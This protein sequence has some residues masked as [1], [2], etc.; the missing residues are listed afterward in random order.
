[1]TIEMFLILLT[2]FSV[3]TSLCTEAAKKFLDSLEVTYASNIIA[4]VVAVFVGGGGTVIFYLFNGIELNL[5]NNIC[6]FLMMGANW[7]GSMI[8]Y[9]KVKQAI[10]QLS[11]GKSNGN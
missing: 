4:L 10:I 3:L 2:A 6:V 9:D 8:G 5:V 11:G 7:L 1:M